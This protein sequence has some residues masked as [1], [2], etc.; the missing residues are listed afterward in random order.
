MNNCRPTVSIT[1]RPDS[2]VA[3]LSTGRLHPCRN[4][5][6]HLM[7][8]FKQLVRPTSELPPGLVFNRLRCDSAQQRAH[9]RFT[10]AFASLF[11]T[12]RQKATSSRLSAPTPPPLQAPAAA[13]TRSRR[14]E[15]PIA[16]RAARS[17]P[18]FRGFVPWRFS[19][20]GPDCGARG[21]ARRGGRAGIR[22]PSQDRSSQL[23][24]RELLRVSFACDI[25]RRRDQAGSWRFEAIGLQGLFDCG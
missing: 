21:A 7:M 4:Q 1:A 12:E 13:Q 6:R 3:R 11:L 14:A 17:T 19:N 9:A 8:R 18:H 16:A 2:A 24:N 10:H 20:A 25:A 22:K 23:A 15:I 5:T